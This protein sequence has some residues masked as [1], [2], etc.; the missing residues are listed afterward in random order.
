[1]ISTRAERGFLIS[2]R[3][4]VLALAVSPVAALSPAL[5]G[6]TQ[7]ALQITSPSDGSVV[8]PGQTISVSVTSPA[9]ISFKQVFV[10]GERPLPTSTIANSVPASFS[11]LI[12]QKTRPGK[13]VLTAWGTTTANQVQPSAAVTVDVERADLPTSLTANKTRI[14]FESQGER[15]P[16]RISGAFADGSVVDLTVSSNLVYTSSNTSVA[17]V[18]NNG[19][20]TGIAAGTASITATYGQGTQSVHVS[21]SVTVPPPVLTP[22][23]TALNFSNQNVGTSSSPETVTITNVSTNQSLKVGPVSTMG[24]F[25]ETD[26]CAS[27]SPIGVG[28]MCTINVTFKPTAAGARIGA[29]S[30]P[31]SMDIVPLTV[32][33]NGTGV[34]V[35]TPAITNLDPGQGFGGTAVTITGTNFGNTQGSSTVKFGAVAATTT[36]WSASSIVALAPQSS[37]HDVVVNVVVTVGGVAS[38]AVQFTICGRSD[39]SCSPTGP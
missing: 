11:I 17:T 4:T 25:S 38:N 28:G 34:G 8:T 36:S 21:V 6:Q 27:S 31:E 7:P 15:L 19:V 5:A 12:P 13:Y 32:L 9:N 20:V 37:L 26:N 39:V 16:L 22:S 3:A 24:D 35:T 18:D 30:V 10:I 33:L 1:M 23:P 29:V 2:L 14:S